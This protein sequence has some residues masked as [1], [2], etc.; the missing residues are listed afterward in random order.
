MYKSCDSVLK[1][2]GKCSRPDEPD[3]A[4]RTN[5]TYMVKIKPESRRVNKMNGRRT[6]RDNNQSF[7]VQILRFAAAAEQK[8][9][10]ETLKPP[11]P[12]V[13][14]PFTLHHLCV[15]NLWLKLKPGW[16]GVCPPS[17]GA[18]ALSGFK[19]SHSPMPISCPPHDPLLPAMC[20]IMG[21]NKEQTLICYHPDEPLSLILDHSLAQT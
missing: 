10:P 18:D 8:S 6:D 9:P 5:D 7:C 11:L 12:T 20:S 14:S 13:R 21:Q 2:I 3:K 16:S 17:S 15:K 19:S 1:E 4:S